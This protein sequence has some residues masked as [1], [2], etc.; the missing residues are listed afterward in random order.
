MKTILTEVF[1]RILL[2]AL[3]VFSILMLIDT[4]DF[5]RLVKANEDAGQ[6]TVCCSWYNPNWI[7][8][9]YTNL[10]LAMETGTYHWTKNG[11]GEFWYVRDVQIGNTI[12][13]TIIDRCGGADPVKP[14][15]KLSE[16]QVKL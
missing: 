7:Y 4:I 5:Y 13:W 12:F 9:P 10:R 8:S 2:A 6:T 16:M 11:V 3:G 15:P 1:R 14:C